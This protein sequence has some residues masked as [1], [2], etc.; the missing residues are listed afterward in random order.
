MNFIQKILCLGLLV[1]CI[2]NF[3]FSQKY[4]LNKECPSD[5]KT[6]KGVLPNGMTYFIRHNKEPKE[7]ASFY[8]IQNVGALLEKDNQNG[9]A[10]F[11]EHMAFNGTKHFPGKGI[12]NTLEKHGVSFGGNINAYTSYD[13]TVYN[14]SDVPTTIPNLLDTCLLVLNDWSNELLLTKEELD[15]ERG[16]ITE[17]WRTRRTPGFRIR[18]QINSALYKGSMW[19]IRDVI[20]DL[21][22][23]KNFKPKEIRDFYHDWYRTDLQ[24]IAIVGDF[25]AKE[26]E[27]KVIKLFSKIPAVKNPKKKPEFLIPDNKKMIFKVATDKEVQQ[28]NLTLYFKHKD[29]SNNTLK[30]SRENYLISF[31][32]S[33]LSS[34]ISELLQKGIPQFISGSSGYGGLVKGYNCYTVSATAKP[35]MEKEAL[36]AIYTEVMRVKKYGF[37]Q[38]ELDRAKMNMQASL[39]SYIKRSKKVS[40]DA[41]CKTY[42]GCFINKTTNAT[43]QF[44]YDFGKY[45]IENIQLNEINKLADKWLTQNN[46]VLIISGPSENI[47]HLSENEALEV[48]KKVEEKNIAPYVDKLSSKGL[49]NNEIKGGKI[50]LEQ[51]IKEI[52]AIEWTLSNGVRVAYKFADFDKDNVYLSARSEGGSSMYENDDLISAFSVSQFIK[53]Y[54]VGNYN[55]VELGKLL[56]GKN[57]SVLPYLGN[58]TE[59][60][61]GGCSPKDFETMLQLLYLYFE[62]PRFDKQAH[63]AFMSRNYAAI[64]NMDKNPQKAMQDSV[65]M[66]FSYYNP[67]VK[68]MNKEYLDNIDLNKIERI[69]KERFRDASDFKF[70]IVG[71][72]KK[73]IVKPLIAKYLGAL[74]DIERKETWVDR[75]M[76]NTPKKVKKKLYFPMATPKGTSILSFSKKAKY[77]AYNRICQSIIANVLNLR[78]TENIREKEGGTYG[79]SVSPSVVKK[80]VSKLG[81]SINFSSDPEKVDYLKSLVFKE[82]NILKK[83]GPLKADFEKTIKALKK[84]HQQG[85]DKNSY[86]F[87]VLKS[88][89][90]HNEN[91]LDPNNFENIIDRLKPRNI[92][93]AAKYFFKNNKEIDVVLLPKKVK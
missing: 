25:D 48:I 2:T 54:G 52:D 15:S 63:Q 28:S 16:V 46:R 78:Y 26:M 13:E 86:W 14:I 65:N 88:F 27:Q 59:G 89:Y 3:S 23:I 72:V 33:M 69:Y 44:Y 18:N 82:I 42:K 92:R 73:E 47:N 91:Y 70:V 67:R 9:L 74:R 93:K 62:K 8:I 84:N 79:V 32:N 87:G 40:N 22:I 4:D 85:R 81:L 55:A 49:I 29:N 41:Y 83:K 1:F 50:I 30:Y 19:A 80:P 5:S 24:A 20:G 36:E 6:I 39:D 66:I 11:L 35:N 64:K 21:N 34:R 12:I 77:N 60:F 61:S 90:Y 57:V 58:R 76:K 17:E 75:S 56:T 38:S 71:N 68:I 31:Y 45:C 10:H 37:L 53:A 51:K 43:P 7:R